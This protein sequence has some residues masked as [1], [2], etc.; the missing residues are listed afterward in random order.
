LTLGLTLGLG[1]GLGEGDD[2]GLVEV[3]E[4][5]GLSDAAT[6]PGLSEPPE[7]SATET[8]I[9]RSVAATAAAMMV[10]RRR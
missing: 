5:L 4:A 7:R 10:L 6:V 2:D 8:T 9:R 3:G 1:L